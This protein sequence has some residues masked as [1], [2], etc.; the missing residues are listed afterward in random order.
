MPKITDPDSLTRGT[1][2]VFD[3]SNPSAKTI[4]LAIAGNL[5]NDGVTLQAV[6]SKCKELWKSNTDLIS[7]HFPLVAITPTQ[8][9]L[10]NGWNWADATTQGLIRDG[11]WAVKNTSGASTEEWACI[12]S[13]GSLDSSSDQIYYQ[14]SSTGS[15]TNF[16]LTG[17][18]NQAIKVYQAG[19]FDRRGFLKLF[20]REQG[21]IYDQANLA[22]IG[23][24]AMTYKDY[25]FPIANTQDLKILATDSSISTLPLYTGMAITYYETDQVR[26]IGGVGY[27]FRV[28]IDGNGAT[29]E[30][31]YGFVQYRLRQSSDIDA[32]LGTVTGKTADSLLK[33][34]GETLV[35]STGVFVENYNA[36]DTNR[37]EFYDTSGTKR[38]YPYIAT[39]IIQFNENLQLDNDA[40]YELFFADTFG[41]G[42]GITVNNANGTPIRGFTGG[43]FSIPFTYDYD[44][45]TQRGLGTEGTEAPVIA[46]AIGLEKAQ[47]INATSTIRR[48]TANTINL[49]AGLERNYI[50]IN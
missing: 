47:Y 45:N 15:A 43:A 22:D 35:T 10:I 39:G 3:F 49:V 6:Y 48:S 13:L 14:Q 27:N 42:E 44:G 18:I 8:F 19:S 37:I 36:A 34:V 9:D 2:I 38:T 5:S 25:A 26:T 1:E 29:I 33:F 16:L 40:A 32:G 41:S 50:R 24:V 30:Q 12:V 7:V 28:V 4:R 21:K 11:G 20:C 31:I 17:P 23:V 46:V